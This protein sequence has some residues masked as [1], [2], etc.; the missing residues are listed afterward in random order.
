MIKT[1]PNFVNCCFYGTDDRPFRL[2]ISD[3]QVISPFMSYDDAEKSKKGTFIIYK[4]GSVAVK[5]VGK[6]DFN[7]LD[8]SNI[9][10]AIQGFN[11]NYEANDSKNLISSMNK[12]G[13]NDDIHNRNC[14]RPGFGYNYKTGKVVIA[15]KKTNAKGLRTLMRNLGCITK[16]NDTCGIGGDSGGSIALAV[17]GKLIQNG[18]RR[19]VSILTW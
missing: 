16:D 7:G 1:L 18:N 5:T 6:N 10:L 19:Q 14:L 13:W 2:V 3:G 11:F 17:G 12:E 15:V 9:N 8:I 4:S